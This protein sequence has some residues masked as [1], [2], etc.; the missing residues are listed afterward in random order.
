MLHLL[1]HISN[2]KDYSKNIKKQQLLKEYFEHI[3]D[4][5]YALSLR[6]PKM[7]AKIQNDIIDAH[8]NIDQSLE[9]FANNKILQTTKNQ[10]FTMTAANN[11]ANFLSD[12]LDSS[13][14]PSQG[15]GQGKG[16]GKGKGKGQG[17]SLPD[18]IQK[19]S[20]LLS[21]AQKQGKKK[22][23]EKP[24]GKDGKGQK[25]EK[26]KSGKG[27][28]SGKDGKNGQNG[29]S[30]EQQQGELFKIYQE[31]NALR[32]Q[33]QDLL[34]KAGQNG[35]AGNKALKQMEDLERMLINKGITNEVLQKM[36]ILKHE[37]LKLDKAKLEQG[38]DDKRKSDTNKKQFEKRDIKAIETKK[39]FFNPNEILNR[40]ALPL[41]TFYKKKVQNYFQN[42][43]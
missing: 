8:Y 35:S 40:Q 4:S 39:I 12:L 26:G 41:H 24:N 20:D 14:N 25:G 7:S 31:Q 23:G 18:I 42:N 1:S 22:G 13:Q 10:Q 11:F 29:D 38:E 27:G 33:F 15:Q 30:D 43:N 21:K 17:E 37:L 34:N 5:I 32:E 19:Q 16:K 3:D 2:R 9:N 36:Q 28:K 6:M